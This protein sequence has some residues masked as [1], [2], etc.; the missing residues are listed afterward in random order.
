MTKCARYD[1]TCN[2]PACEADRN[3]RPFEVDF[4]SR[5]K[6][7]RRWSARFDLKDARANSEAAVKHAFDHDANIVGQR[8]LCGETLAKFKALY[9]H[10]YGSAP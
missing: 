2:C 4:Q 10:E 7:G 3:E 6:S 8:F 9:G 1:D 5:L